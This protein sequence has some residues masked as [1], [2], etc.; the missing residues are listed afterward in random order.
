MASVIFSVLGFFFTSL[1][2][3]LNH[4]FVGHGPLGKWPLLR[5][6]RRLH[7][8][9]HKN[10]YNDS[11]D[12]HLVLPI[13]AKLAFLSV[14]GLISII[15]I[16]FAVGYITY[17]IYYGWLHYKIHNDDQTGYCSN[18]HYLH[19]RKSARHNFSGTMP[20]ID[21]IFGTKLNNS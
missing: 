7:L 8:K 11:R 12:E 6:I 20:I 19:H 3:Y 21:K 9:H 4:R 15:S 2:F 1:M 17:V 5:H 14:F 10:D 13:W 18:H 16:P